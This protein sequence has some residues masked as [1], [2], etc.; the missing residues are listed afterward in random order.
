MRDT[1][2]LCHKCILHIII[3]IRTMDEG[4]V[5]VAA[6]GEAVEE[7]ITKMEI[8]IMMTALRLLL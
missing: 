3:M 4:E 8:M 7:G 2:N 5:E 6:E 1:R